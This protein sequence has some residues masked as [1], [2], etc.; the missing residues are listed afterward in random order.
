MTK[1]SSRRVRDT[2]KRNNENG[3]RLGLLEEL[4]SDF[5]TQRHRVYWFNFVRGV[6]FGIGSVIGG[7]LLVALLIWILTQV[8][9]LV[10]FL[11]D[12]IQQIMDALGRRQA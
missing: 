8:G 1:Q 3:A 9:A 5:Y 11:S 10:P 2:I 7:T 6:F 12:F 4:F